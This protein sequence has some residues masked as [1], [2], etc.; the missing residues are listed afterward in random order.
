MDRGL[1]WAEAAMSPVFDSSWKCLWTT[2]HAS[3][4]QQWA[5]AETEKTSDSGAERDTS[6]RVQSKVVIDRSC[7]RAVLGM[8]NE[9]LV[10][11]LYK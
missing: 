11:S 5:V 10:L 6:N 9:V 4:G 8:G 7:P 3:R 2:C 1:G